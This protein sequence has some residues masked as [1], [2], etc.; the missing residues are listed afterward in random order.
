M[1]TLSA[2]VAIVG[3]GPVGLLLA[4][5]LREAGVPVIVVER[6][7]EPM[8]ES[9][10]TQLTSRSASLLRARGLESLLT[11]TESK[12]HFGGLSFE[13]DSPLWKVPQ[14]RT[15]AALTKRAFDLG[16]SLL[17][18]H[19]L[20]GIGD[21]LEV[22]G[23]LGTVAI[24]SEHVVGC[25]GE[26]STVRRLAGFDYA[27]RPATRELLRADV[28][29]LSVPDRR[30]ERFE[31]GLA[32]AATRGDVTRV[33]VHE[34]GRSAARTEPVTFAEI[35][36][37]WAKVT[38]ED[39]AGGKPLWADAFDNATGLVSSYREGN[40][41]LA[42][43]AAHRHL[44]VGGQALNVGLQDAAALATALTGGADTLLDDYART[45]RAAALAVMELVAAQE[46]LLLG[47]PEV[48]PL[49]EVLTELFTVDAAR[50][51]LARAVEESGNS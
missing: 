48:E 24:E 37:V 38:G 46:L 39:I 18:S 3:A 28:T 49:R 21:H 25:D 41:L 13:L 10:A 12:A 22:D 43:D 1:T 6:L 15:E 8:T 26:N 34:F 23:P 5:D 44:P 20:T 33:M 32:V 4:G 50:A 9:R 11:D 7:P 31:H 47:G 17:R 36:D 14:P 30:F 2:G 29:G 16:V 19:T 45:R 27:F 51:H 35:T 42:G 40:V